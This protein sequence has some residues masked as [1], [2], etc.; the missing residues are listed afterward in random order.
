MQLIKHR[1]AILCAFTA[2][3][4]MATATQGAPQKIAIVK[5]DDVRGVTPKW[6]RFFALSKAKGIKVSAGIICNSLQQDRQGYH[7]WLRQ[8]AASGDVEFWNHGWDHKRWTDGKVEKREFDSSGYP[9]QKTH[10]EDA[11][12]LMKKV[13]GTSPIASGAPFNATDA[14]TTKVLNENGESRLFFCYKA[15]G[16]EHKVLAPMSWSGENN[17]TGKPDFIKFKTGSL[18]YGVIISRKNGIYQ[19]SG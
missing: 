18:K 2:I 10:F 11:Q 19:F 14:D 3:F 8:L 4:F 13:L 1:R 5:A 16:L 12:N 6:K 15:K 9:H 17:G 7:A